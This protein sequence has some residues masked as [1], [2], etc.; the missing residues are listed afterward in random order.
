M[1]QAELYGSPPITKTFMLS[2][3]KVYG[4]HTTKYVY[5]LTHLSPL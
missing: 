4:I 5:L 2:T 3:I 1:G